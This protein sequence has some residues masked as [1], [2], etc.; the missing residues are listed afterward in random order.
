MSQIFVGQ[1]DLTL[2]MTV[3]RDITGATVTNIAFRKPNGDQGEFNA[4]IEDATNGILAYPAIDGELDMEGKWTF[5]AEI[6]LVSGLKA[7]GTPYEH[8]IYAPGK[9]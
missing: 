8:T 6:V 1:T 5:W 9:K 2:R 4:S 7:I 3:N